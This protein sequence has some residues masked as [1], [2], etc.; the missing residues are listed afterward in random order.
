M[1]NVPDPAEQGRIMRW[2]YRD[3]R[4]TGLARV[5]NR[6]DGWLAAAGLPP[7]SMVA[8]EVTGRSTDRIRTTVLAMP[9]CGGN[10]YPVSML[11]NNS[12]WMR[13]AR[14]NPDA[15]IRHG[16]WL[17]VRLAEIPASHRAPVL[18]EY[19]RI[20]RSGRRHF[21]VAPGA[22]LSEFDAVADRY[23]VFRIEPR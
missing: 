13:N 16:R 6:I 3:W 17:S 1:N 15:V 22:P 21:P 23:P 19:V 18:K 5:V 8:L 12:S 10:R 11:G 14:A 4:P 9:H 20:A 2:L 7:R